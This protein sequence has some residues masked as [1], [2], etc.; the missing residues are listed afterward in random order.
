MATLAVV[1]RAIRVLANAERAKTNAW[2][3]KTGKG[4]YGEG[5]CF[6]GLRGPEMRVIAKQYHGLALRSVEQLLLSKWH[7]DRQ[8]GVLILAEQMRRG[9]ATV[10]R[11]VYDC[12]LAHTDRINN[13][14]LVD[15]SAHEVVGRY[16]LEERKSTNVLDRLAKSKLLWDRRIAMIA[17]FT[18]IRAGEFDVAL[19]IA[20]LLLHDEHDLMHKAV[21]WMLREVGNRDRAT[22]EQFLKTRYATMPR[23]MLRYAI[24]KF[25]EP[26]RKAYLHG[27]VS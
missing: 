24:E 20:D 7:E 11:V 15:V 19:R 23:T 4:E 8:V 25:P 6:L 12:Y 18:F 22:E 3:F 27:T 16:L 5:D 17:T 9:D 10:R 2:F 14:D 21:G 26:R 13:W 1:R